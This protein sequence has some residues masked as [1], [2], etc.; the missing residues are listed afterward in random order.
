MQGKGK[1][2]SAIFLFLSPLPFSFFISF[3][4]NSPRNTTAAIILKIKLTRKLYLL[5]PVFF[6]RLS[7][8][9]RVA[10]QGSSAQVKLEFPAP[11]A[12]AHTLTLYFM[13]DAYL[14]CDQ[15]FEVALNIKAS[16]MEVDA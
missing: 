14:G 1:L 13:C 10:I 15:E 11:A 3:P 8:I 4:P 9:K 12:G 7:S 6:Y 2:F 16:S 5:H